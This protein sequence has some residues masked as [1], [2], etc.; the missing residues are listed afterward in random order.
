MEGDPLADVLTLASARCVRVGTLKAGGTWALKFP[1]PQ[2]IKL[3]AVVKGTCWLAVDGERTPLRLQTGDVFMVPAARSY[4]LASDL[5]ASQLDGLALFT[6]ATDSVAT[7]GNGEDFFAIGGHVDLDP[8]RGGVLADVLPP[9]I[10]VDAGSSEAST[11][12]WLLDQLVKEVTAN[13]PGVVLAS[14]Q[15]AQLLFVQIIRFYLASS[16]TATVGW[17]RALSDERIA[18]ALRLMHGEPGRPWRLG[19]LAKHAGMSRTSFALRF[20]AN[21]GVAP[22]TY[23]QNLRMRMAEQGLREGHMSVSEL[24]ESLGYES[25]SAFSNAF[26]RRTG[27]A[28]KHYQSVL[29]RMDQP[30]SDAADPNPRHAS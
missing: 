23:L 4:V 19:E 17:L 16:N 13:R 30:T 3:I 15:L 21:A 22:L 24:A 26:K 6:K 11:I 9:L 20:K 18:P 29:A 8:D 14:K 7:V 28:P 10:H 27:M 5:K 12:R 25:D 2:K 1:P